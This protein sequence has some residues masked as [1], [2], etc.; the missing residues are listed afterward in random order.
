[1]QKK[2]SY[3]PE[4]GFGSLQQTFKVGNFMTYRKHNALQIAQYDAMREW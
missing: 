4:K 2:R 1:M 3:G